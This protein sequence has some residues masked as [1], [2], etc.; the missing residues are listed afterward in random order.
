MRVREVGDE[1]LGPLQIDLFH[2]GFLENG[3]DEVGL[4][5][6]GLAEIGVRQV[7]SNEDRPAEIRAAQIRPAEV[8]LD[9]DCAAQ[10]GSPEIGARKFRAPKVRPA[11]FDLLHGDAVARQRLHAG[12]ERSR[13]LA[14]RERVG[15]RD[16]REERRLANAA[17]DLSLLDVDGHTV[18]AHG[19]EHDSGEL[20]EESE[21][22]DVAEEVIEPAENVFDAMKNYY[23]E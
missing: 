15:A 1:Q 21:A 23:G 3:A 5:E 2:V 6:V 18:D 9:E 14:V 8:R 12:F 20:Q 11:E 19:E 7:R 22:G 10:I 16:H 13:S 17:V 4:A